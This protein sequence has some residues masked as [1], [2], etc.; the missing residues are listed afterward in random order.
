MDLPDLNFTPPVEDVDEMN[1]MEGHVGDEMEE[2]A[3]QGTEGDEIVQN[4]GT[5]TVDH[6]IT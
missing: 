1:E 6:F 4:P 5:V 3:G 2:D